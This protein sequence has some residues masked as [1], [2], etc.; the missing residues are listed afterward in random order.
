MLPIK[1]GITGRRGRQL[2]GRVTIQLVAIV[3][4]A[5]FKLDQLIVRVDHGSRVEG[6]VEPVAA[7]AQVRSKLVEV[8]YVFC[9]SGWKFT[10]S[11][12][13]LHHNTSTVGHSPLNLEEVIIVSTPLN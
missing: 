9:L 11:H 13:H 7:S 8:K 5:D 12:F 1:D 10:Q 3:A 4:N 2:D 6:T